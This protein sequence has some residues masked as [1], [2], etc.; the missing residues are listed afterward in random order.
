[1]SRKYKV[2]DQESLHFITY[3]VVGWVDASGYLEDPPF[4]VIVALR[5]PFGRRPLVRPYCVAPQSVT[6]G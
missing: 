5:R 6:Y 4:G 1:M 2:R 3:S